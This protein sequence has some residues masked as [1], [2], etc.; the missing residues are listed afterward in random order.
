MYLVP[1]QVAVIVPKLKIYHTGSYVVLSQM[2]LFV[3]RYLVSKMTATCLV[4]MHC[5]GRQIQVNM[6]LVRVECRRAMS[7][8]V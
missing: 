1:V 2:K 8:Y 5:T 7:R 3:Y 6:L 4:C